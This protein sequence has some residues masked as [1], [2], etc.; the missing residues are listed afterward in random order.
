M[1]S[2]TPACFLLASLLAGCGH[3]PLTSL[4]KLSKVDIRTT[5]LTE[6]RAGISLP[7]DIR[8]LPGGITMTIVAL[9]KDGGRHER[10]VVLEEVREAGELAKLPVVAAPGRRFT[11]FRLSDGDAAR[12]SA[13][14]EEMFVGPHNSSNRGSLALM[15]EK[16]CRIGD[17][18]GKTIPM[19]SYLKTSETEEYVLLTRDIDLRDAVREADPKLDLATA[20]PPCDAIAGVS[21][22]RAVP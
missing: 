19:T 22:S 9:P 6:L 20:I 15:A 21:G 1:H 16:A 3:V 4:P 13:F 7:A 8:P 18:S 17:L 10:K 2:A 5:R 14:R 11:V 12:I